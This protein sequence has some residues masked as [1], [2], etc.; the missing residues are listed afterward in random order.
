MAYTRKL[1][2]F[3]GLI[4]AIIWTVFVNYTDGLLGLWFLPK[5]FKMLAGT[6]YIVAYVWKLRKLR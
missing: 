6:I 1:L 3:L 4:L 5:W 2:L